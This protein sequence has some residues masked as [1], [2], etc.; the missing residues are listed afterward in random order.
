MLHARGEGTP[1]DADQALAWFR[2]AAANNHL[3]AQVKAGLTLA[4]RAADA[5]EALFWLLS[6]LE[7]LKPGAVRAQAEAAVQ[8][9][10]QRLDAARVLAV[11]QRIADSQAVSSGSPPSGIT[12]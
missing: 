8:V 1:A 5:E 6:A 11:R 3:D 10:E 4:S 12:E 7:R 9:L 2:K